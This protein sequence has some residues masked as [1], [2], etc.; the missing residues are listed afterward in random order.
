MAKNRLFGNRGEEVPPENRATGECDVS[1]E[2]IGDERQVS[3]RYQDAEQACS[4]FTYDD[5]AEQLS[6]GSERGED[7]LENSEKEK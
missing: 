1:T 7:D 5:G 2:E 6:A 4:D 3:G